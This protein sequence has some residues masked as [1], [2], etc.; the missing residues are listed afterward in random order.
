MLLD[1]WGAVRLGVKVEQA[2]EMWSVLKVLVDA[3]LVLLAES[4]AAW[5]P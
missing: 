1:D 2:L 5:E 3:V 4:L